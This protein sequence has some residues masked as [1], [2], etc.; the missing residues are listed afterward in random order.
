LL[1]DIDMANCWRE[2]VFSILV[3][4]LVIGFSAYA[5]DAPRLPVPL[6]TPTPSPSPEP[7]ESPETEPADPQEADEPEES[8]PSERGTGEEP[9][10]EV[11]D[12]EVTEWEDEEGIAH[13]PHGSFEV[14][15]IE[16]EP[17]DLKWGN[18]VDAVRGLGRYSLFDGRLKFRLGMKIQADA[19]AGA[20]SD[21]YE[22]FYN[23]FKN[24]VNLR[25][26]RAYAAGVAKNMNFLIG[27]EFGSD[28]GFKDV[29]VEGRE[30]GLRVWGHYLGKL[31]VGQMREPFSLERQTSSFFT[32]FAERSLPVQAFAPGHNIG[33]MVHDVG[34][35]KRMTWAVGLFSFGRSNEDNASTS[36]LSLTTRWTFLPMYR[37]EGRRLIHFG[38]SFSTRSPTSGDTRYFSRPEAR[39]AQI[40]VDTGDMDVSQTKLFGFEYASVHGPMWIQA[41]Y[42]RADL[43]AQLLG[44]PTFMGSYG[45]VGFSLT[46]DVRAYKQNS[47]VFGRMEPDKNYRGGNPFKKKNG[48]A[49]EIVGRVSRVDLTDAEVDG[50]ILTDISAALNW[51]VN[52][53]T[54]I[55][56]NY[57]YA[58]PKNRGAANIF[59]LRLQYIPW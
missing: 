41:E 13:S 27:F 29:W 25:R 30:G 31:R 47:G 15:S 45:Q 55:V 6:P 18:F 32:G 9:E 33:T 10:G 44:D 1:Y 16:T 57:I 26:F 42:I 38:G 22:T 11:S 3:A 58:S 20:G 23:P 14:D 36:T 21:K 35:N 28:W 34:A 48:G 4:W 52:P 49:W 8:G 51:Y 59:L 12:D 5:Q 17:F 53:T 2:L 50:G 19:T 40:L 46:G 7:P 54:R 37:N 56:L 43:D 24:T 39:F